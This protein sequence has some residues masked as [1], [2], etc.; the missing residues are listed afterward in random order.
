MRCQLLHLSIIKLILMKIPSMALLEAL[1][2]EQLVRLPGSYEGLVLLRCDLGSLRVLNSV[3]QRTEARTRSAL[4]IGVEDAVLL[5]HLVKH[6]IEMIDAFCPQCAPF[7]HL[8]LP[9]DVFEVLLEDLGVNLSQKTGELLIVEKHLVDVV[10]PVAVIGTVEPFN[11]EMLALEEL[12]L[13][14]AVF[15]EAAILGHPVAHLFHPGLSK[16]PAALVLLFRQFLRNIQ[17]VR[18]LRNRW[19]LL[20]E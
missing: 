11:S 12:L 13:L 6:L 1:R 9:L 19:P 4:I 16:L 15:H 8:L 20:V 17:R 3:L 14:H 7:H 2:R 18:L 10:Q 5:N